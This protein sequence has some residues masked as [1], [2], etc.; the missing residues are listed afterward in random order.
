MRVLI[1][2]DEP[3]AC[4][5]LQALLGQCCD[6]E[7]MA[8]VHDGEAAL[9][10][11]LADPPD[12]VLAD[13]HMPGMPGTVLSRRLADLPRPPQVVFCTAHE[14]FAAEAFVLGAADYLLK[15]VPLARLR[16]ALER[17][18]RLRT[19][20]MLAAA[21][22]IRVRIGNEEHRIMLADVLFLLAD[23]KYVAVHHRGGQCLSDTSLRQ[24][25]TQQPEQ[26]VRIHRNCLVP[27][28]RLLGLQTGR[29]G[30]VQA[31]LA[32]CDFTPDISRRNLAPV[33]KLLRQP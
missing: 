10:A 17:A 29:D 24:F 7:V 14:Q 4:T 32:G 26:W 8:P 25:E 18:R 19:P 9:E 3:L 33:R 5:R 20:S 6:I 11:C 16:E 2:D 21:P 1:V 23:D 12:L 27:R 22:S 15:P 13:I 31:R 28:T 30:R